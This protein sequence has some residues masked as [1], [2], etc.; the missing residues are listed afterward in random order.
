MENNESLNNKN[1]PKK[2][3]EKALEI[4]PLYVDS[5]INT[6]ILPPPL[7]ELSSHIDNFLSEISLCNKEFRGIEIQNKEKMIERVWKII[8]SHIK[9]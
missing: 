3:E 7:P 9:D 6:E 5:P 1:Y 4:W 2:I 8:L